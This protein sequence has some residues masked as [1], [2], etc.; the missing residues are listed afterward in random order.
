MPT[1]NTAQ[2]VRVPQIGLR[3]GG[4]KVRRAGFAPL[5][6]VGV[7]A[8][9]ESN[10]LYRTPVINEVPVYVVKHTDDYMLYMLI[11]TKVKCY[12][13]EPSGCLTIAL[14]ITRG[15]QMQDGKSPYTLMREVYEL[16]VSKY[17]RT[18]AD[19][20]REFLNVDIDSELFRPIV[21]QY[22][23]EQSVC[24]HVSMSPTGS[25]GVACVAE[26]KLA[27]FF[28][29]TNHK[30]FA[31]YKD[32]EIGTNCQASVSPGLDNLIIP[33]PKTA[34][35]VYV[36]GDKQGHK[37]SL[38]TDE[39]TASKDNTAF[40]TYK[41]V[42]FC[43]K[44]VLDAPDNRLSM[45]GATVTLDKQGRRIDC[46]MNPEPVWYDITV[47]WKDKAE[48]GKATVQ[49]G[50]RQKDIHFYIGDDSIDEIIT[51]PDSKDKRAKAEKVLNKQLRV[52]PSTL[53]AGVYKY[54]V[55]TD[56][57][58]D[59]DTKTCIITITVDKSL[60]QTPK[61]IT[62]TTIGGGSRGNVSGKKDD[63]KKEHDDEKKDGGGHGSQGNGN[64]NDKE[65]FHWKELFIG[66]IATLAIGLAIWGAINY[67]KV[68]SESEVGGNDTIKTTD[69]TEVTPAPSVEQAKK[70]A[71]QAE[72][73]ADNAEQELKK[74]EEQKQREEA[75]I[76]K[77]QAEAE[78]KAKK[79]E[80]KAEI[81]E[82]LKQ[83]KKVTLNDPKYK[84]VLTVAER[85]AVAAIQDPVHAV[86]KKNADGTPWKP[87]GTQKRNAQKAINNAPINSWDDVMT[88]SRT[89][90]SVLQ[91]E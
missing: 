24:D 65:Q 33:L 52:S 23:L 27:Q 86:K 84:G 22:P 83:K 58:V 90:V 60:M 17:M 31:P 44:D 70:A 59:R 82:L 2:P 53:K 37:M 13:A 41:P 35:E 40:C 34:F 56:M 42:T 8:G 11:D 78:A 64:G 61:P 87:D 38:P 67:F 55:L 73:E 91:A 77:K 6:T 63:K 85:N 14:S 43:L 12:D 74:L 81:L 3:I 1:N 21:M 62:V 4:T 49:K 16:F 5:A 20:R 75:A 76:A 46:K 36:N 45:D 18:V 39:Y 9:N 72:N 7:L 57:K 71:D 54:N 26:D 88:L 51:S 89:I 68:D 15:A 80:L 69:T 30:C 25:T 19:G 29:N 28:E 79:A 50:I 32:I 47:E 48:D 66:V 10:N